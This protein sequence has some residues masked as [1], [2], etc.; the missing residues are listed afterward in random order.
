MKKETKTCECKDIHGGKGTLL[1]VWQD[2]GEIM[3][4]FC[5]NGVVVRIPKRYWAK[6]KK[7]LKEI[8]ETK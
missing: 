6:I 7:E 2:E 5:T 4:S 1:Q 3:F 8:G